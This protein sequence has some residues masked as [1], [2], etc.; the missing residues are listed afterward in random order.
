MQD[1]IARRPLKRRRLFQRRPHPDIEFFFIRQLDQAGR[2]ID[3]SDEA[4]G[5]DGQDAGNQARSWDR[6]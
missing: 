4:T 3:G 2:N 1:L 5:L 6:H